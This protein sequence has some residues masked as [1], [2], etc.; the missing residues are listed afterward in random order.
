MEQRGRLRIRAFRLRDLVFLRAAKELQEE[1]TPKA[2]TELYEAILTAPPR[3]HR[4][5]AIE[6]RSRGLPPGRR[7]PV[8]RA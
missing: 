5:R 7:E 8:E 2:R 4:V 3:G 1:L 6:G